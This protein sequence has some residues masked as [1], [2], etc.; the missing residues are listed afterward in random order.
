MNLEER[1]KTEAAA[2]LWQAFAGTLVR[3][4]PTEYDWSCEWIKDVAFGQDYK[5]L[6]I[7]KEYLN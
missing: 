3:P 5:P 1:I 4:V 2:K 7:D 6:I